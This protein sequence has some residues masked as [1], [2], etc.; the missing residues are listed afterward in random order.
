M[1]SIPLHPVLLILVDIASP[2]QRKNK[3]VDKMLDILIAF[4]IFAL[5]QFKNAAKV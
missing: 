5:L 2:I 3:V 4:G 1:F